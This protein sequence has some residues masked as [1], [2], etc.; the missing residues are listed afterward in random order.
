MP[1]RPETPGRRER[2]T[3]TLLP[4]MD[5]LI[6]TC[7]LTCLAWDDCIDLL[8]KADAARGRELQQFHDQC[9]SYARR[10]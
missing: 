5:H 8:A 4:L 3:E 10:A 9:L 6:A 2:Q 7:R 1:L